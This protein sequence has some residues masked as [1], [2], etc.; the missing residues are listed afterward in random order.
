MKIVI[1]VVRSNEQHIIHLMDYHLG[2]NYFWGF[3]F[4]ELT[5]IDNRDQKNIDPSKQNTHDLHGNTI[6]LKF[7]FPMRQC[8]G[9]LLVY[10]SETNQIGL[11]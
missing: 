5:L 8:L 7:N 9:T 3:A 1:G 11:M 6:L 2:M 10:T 4:V